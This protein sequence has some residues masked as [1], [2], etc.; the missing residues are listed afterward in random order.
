MTKKSKPSVQLGSSLLVSLIMLVII[1]LLALSAIRASNINLRI[2]GNVQ[3]RDEALS[4]AQQAIEQ[5]V[6]SYPRFTATPP[7]GLN[8]DIDVNKDGTA[9]YAVVIAAPS[10]LRAAPQIPARTADCAS[11]AKSGLTCWDTL[12][13]LQA[14]ATSKTNSDVS[15]VVTQGVSISFGPTFQPTSAGCQ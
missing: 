6:S 10:C 8:L 2:A 4:A 3:T 9:D 7:S 15:Q 11:G 5:Y 1:T 13:N 14:T 12:W